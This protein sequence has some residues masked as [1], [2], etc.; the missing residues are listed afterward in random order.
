MWGCFNFC[1]V[2]HDC[3]WVTLD[4]IHFQVRM[5]F[6]QIQVSAFYITHLSFYG[7]ETICVMRSNAGCRNLKY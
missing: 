2:V 4:V 6:D 3:F 5:K 1:T 7:D